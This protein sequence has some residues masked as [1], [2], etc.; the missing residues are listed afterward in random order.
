ML[1]VDIKKM[2]PEEVVEA[3]ALNTKLMDIDYE[4]LEMSFAN[5]LASYLEDSSPLMEQRMLC[6]HVLMGFYQI[7]RNV[8][9]AIADTM[10]LFRYIL[11]CKGHLFIKEEIALYV[12][13]YEQFRVDKMS[14]SNTLNVILDLL[15]QGL[16]N[17]DP[18]SITSL[19]EQ[20]ENQLNRLP[21]MVKEDID[22]DDGFNALK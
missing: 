12:G 8:V 6:H 4:S 15:V 5:I 2:K 3:L 19:M 13:L 21:D 22:L 14:T 1:A 17:S 9:E 16:A 10:G 7:E 11:W 20:L 18:E